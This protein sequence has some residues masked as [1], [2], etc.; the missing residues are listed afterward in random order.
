MT[1]VGQTFAIT[2]AT[3]VG[4]RQIVDITKC[5]DCHQQLALHGN[6]RVGNTDLCAGCHNPNATDINRRVAGSN[7]EAV[8]GTL[9]DQPI[10]L[11][12]MIHAIHAGERANYS[13]CG[14]GN[15]GFNF[16]GV[17]YPGKL[18]NCEGCHVADTYYPP[19]S[20]TAIA[21]TIDAG[22]RTTPLGDIA[23]TPATAACAAC[24][25]DPTAK[26]HM[27]FNGGSFSAVKDAAGG[28]AAVETCAACHGPGTP[29][30][31]KVVHGVGNFNYN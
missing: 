10:D 5:N 4:Y 23:I 6:N 14:F 28:T 21:T 3:P 11:K 19:N 12:Y 31:V 1:S 29:V 9:D 17:V 30:D 13:V 25:T 26:Q 7:C 2:D 27:E 16:A 22:D 8:T 15:T 20:S 18:V 24:H